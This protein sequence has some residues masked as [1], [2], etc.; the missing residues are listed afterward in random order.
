MGPFGQDAQALAEIAP[1][2]G[3]YEME[4]V[5]ACVTSE[6]VIELFVRDDAERRR[7]FMMKGAQ[8]P[9]PVAFLPQADVL[10]HH[11]DD[12]VPLP[13]LIDQTIRRISR[14]ASSFPDVLPGPPINDVWKSF[15][16]Q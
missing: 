13:H 15:P 3:L 2:H 9:V 5:P 16:G 7:L 8:S 6:A 1:F 12:V 10:G 11:L 14:P 4:Y